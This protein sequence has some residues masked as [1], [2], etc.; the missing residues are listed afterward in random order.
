WQEVKAGVFVLCFVNLVL[1]Q[2]P[3]LKSTSDDISSEDDEFSDT[4]DEEWQP[5]NRP[6]STES[7]LPV[8]CNS[9]SMQVILPSGSQSLVHIV[10]D[11]VIQS[12]RK[13]PASCGYSLTEEPGFNVLVVNYTGCH[14]TLEDGSYTLKILYPNE[15][16]KLDF[17]MVSCNE[18]D[19]TTYHRFEQKP[20]N[21]QP[22]YPLSQ[23]NMIALHDKPAGC[24]IPAN[25]RV[26]CGSIDEDHE[27]CLSRGCCFDT[28]SSV[29][30]YAMDECTQDYNFVFVVYND[31]GNSTLN[32]MNLMVSGKKGCQ[33]VITNKDFSIFKFPVTDCG[34][35]SFTIGETV[36][37]LA[38]VK[39]ISKVRKLKYGVISRD[40]PTRLMIECRYPK[41]SEDYGDGPVLASA[42]YMVMSPSLPSVLMSEGLFGVQLLISEDE[43]FTNFYP[44]SYVP[45]NVILGRPVYLELRLKSPKPAA[46]LLVHYCVAYPR[47]AKSALVLLFEGCPNPNDPGNTAVLYDRDL[48][49]NPYQRRFKTKAF[50][51]MDLS[52]DKYL[53]EEIYFMCSTEVCMP[54]GSPCKETCFDGMPPRKP[55]M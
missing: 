17:A 33:P 13:A 40:N 12:I 7:K 27:E 28:K 20:K 45:L 5:E 48:P 42:G 36:I 24:K 49:Q 31:F 39:S 43:T 30:Y 21:G 16:G 1:S 55:G 14:V 9:Q 18:K 35:H 37:Y 22:S 2:N 6:K 19:V 8:S 32:P 47:S 46:T 26:P 11:T 53:D 29:C 4:G 38:E 10:G 25:H 41:V 34:T 51:F 23:S 50:Q 44:R 52:T 15:A 54:S 3:N